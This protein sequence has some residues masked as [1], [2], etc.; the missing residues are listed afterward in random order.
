MSPVA[1]QPPGPPE[2]SGPPI[3]SG[4]D[5]DGFALGDD[6]VLRRYRDGGDVRVEAAIMARAR[7]AAEKILL[8]QAIDVIRS[9]QPPESVGRRS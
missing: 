2:P 9:Y 8:A 5:A 4:R 7:A 3:A 6:K 1:P